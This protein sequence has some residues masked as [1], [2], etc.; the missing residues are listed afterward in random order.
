MFFISCHRYWSLCVSVA[1]SRSCE[2][3]PAILC[4][5]RYLRRDSGDRRRSFLFYATLHTSVSHLGWCSSSFYV[6]STALC[7]YV[8]FNNTRTHICDVPPVIV[9]GFCRLTR[10]FEHLPQSLYVPVCSQMKSTP[11][12]V[13]FEISS[14]CGKS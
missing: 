11:S 10:A 14:D 13:L 6:G 4:R 2:G 12:R 9:F 3:S 7:K 8:C 1:T 5:V